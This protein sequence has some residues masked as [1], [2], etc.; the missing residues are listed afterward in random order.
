MELIK[1]QKLIKLKNIS[2][3]E[4][5]KRM[6]IS[7][8]ALREIIYGTTDPKVSNVEKLAYALNVNIG[9][10]FTPESLDIVEEPQAKYGICKNC[11]IKD[12]TMLL[13]NMRMI[14]LQENNDTLRKTN[15]TLVKC[16]DKLSPED[17]SKEVI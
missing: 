1:I 10:L 12:N 14:T 3:R 9:Y 11:E 5:A 2:Q 6:K 7:I 16:L 13:M 17:K 8:N 4:L 15:E